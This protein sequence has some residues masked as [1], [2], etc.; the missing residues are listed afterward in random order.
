MR[1]PAT[2]ESRSDF[3]GF[4]EDLAHDART[5]L[6][7]WENQDLPAFIEALAA[8]AE[9]IQGY[10]DAHGLRLRSDI[11]TFRL[12]ADLLAGARVYE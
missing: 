10:Y 12:F 5:N 8:Y 4:L 1:D 2:V 11:P 9:D 3:K 6:R 7:S